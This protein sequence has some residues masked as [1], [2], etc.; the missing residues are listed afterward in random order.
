MR[1][2]SLVPGYLLLPH[3]HTS[4][5]QGERKV[6]GAWYQTFYWTLSS[7][8]ASHP[9]NTPIKIIFVLPPDAGATSLP[10]TNEAAGPT[11]GPSDS[12]SEHVY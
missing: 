9:T 6:H 1:S 2:R 7:F 10:S 3:C 4:Y 5:L 11:Q 12:C 8:L